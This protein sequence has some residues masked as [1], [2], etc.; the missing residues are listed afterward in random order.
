MIVRQPHAARS[1]ENLRSIVNQPWRARAACGVD[2]AR[3]FDG[4]RGRYEERPWDRQKRWRKALE[5]CY[6][7]P[8]ILECGQDGEYEEGVRGGRP[9]RLP[10]EWWR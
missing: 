10:N 5:I 6:R 8:V 2:T 9:P 1:Y 7:C 3:L 4:Q